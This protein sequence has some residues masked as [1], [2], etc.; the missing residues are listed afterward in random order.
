MASSSTWAGFTSTRR[1]AFSRR[2][3]RIL[4]LD[5]RVRVKDMCITSGRFRVLLRGSAVVNPSTAMD[6][7]NPITCEEVTTMI[8]RVEKHKFLL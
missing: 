6:I 5:A 2:I 8:S 7:V 1:F 3:R 4:E